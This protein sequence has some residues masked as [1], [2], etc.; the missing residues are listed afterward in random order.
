MKLSIKSMRLHLTKPPPPRKTTKRLELSYIEAFEKYRKRFMSNY[1][2]LVTLIDLN[3]DKGKEL[4]TLM[5]EYHRYFVMLVENNQEVERVSGLREQ[6]EKQFAQLMQQANMSLKLRLFEFER[7]VAGQFD[8]TLVQ[9]RVPDAFLRLS[10]NL[11]K[12]L[13][14][15]GIEH[16]K[17]SSS[18]KPQ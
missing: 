15:V 12:N 1:E 2:T 5:D 18:M 13:V 8:P 11:I 7:L 4:N 9:G 6:Y 14:V 10:D 16:M 3:E 17:L